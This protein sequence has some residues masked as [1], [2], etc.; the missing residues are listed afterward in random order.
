MICLDSKTVKA[1]FEL[2]VEMTTGVFQ[3][4]N[5]TGE[6]MSLELARN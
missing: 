5:K 2:E 3:I 6:I 1:K 4:P